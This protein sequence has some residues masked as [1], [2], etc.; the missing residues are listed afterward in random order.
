MG[1]RGTTT[2]RYLCHLVRRCGQGAAPRYSH[3][4]QPY[5]RIAVRAASDRSGGWCMI[6]P[7]AD[8]GGGGPQWHERATQTT[9]TRS[10]SRSWVLVSGHL[11]AAHRE[12]SRPADAVLACL[13]CHLSWCTAQGC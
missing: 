1:G 4:A 6:L 13:V 11:I 3:K 10:A 8:R 2:A 9:E 12:K 5:R 7:T